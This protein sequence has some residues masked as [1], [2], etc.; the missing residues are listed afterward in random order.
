MIEIN[1]AVQ[2]LVSRRDTTMDKKDHALAIVKAGLNAVPVIGGSLASLIDDYVP[3][4][5]QESIEKV[6]QLLGEELGALKD[7]IDTEAVDKSEFSDLF[8]S[9]YLTIVR[10]SQRSK[11]QAVASILANLLLRRNDPDKLSYNELDHAIRC[12]ESLSIGAIHTLGVAYSLGKKEGKLYKERPFLF[13]FEWLQKSSGIE[14][15]LLFGLVGELNMSNL[16][17]LPGAPSIRTENYGN[18]P[19]ELTPLGVRFVERIL[20]NGG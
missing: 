6:T 4:S 2:S 19:I 20:K 3:S 9:C 1:G 16:L 8:K 17:H 5:T 7:R 14:P 15:S 18:Y 12:V 10:T 11:L 13:D